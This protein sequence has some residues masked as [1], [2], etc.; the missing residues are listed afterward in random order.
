MT[1]TI[2][3][4]TP[5]LASASDKVYANEDLW[6]FDTEDGETVGPFR[7]KSEAEN[8]LSR[9]LEQLQNQLGA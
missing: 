1:K 6:Y 2:N 8:N 3:S 5:S 7:Y 9:F 4:S